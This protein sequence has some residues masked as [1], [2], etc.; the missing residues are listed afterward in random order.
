[1][2]NNVTSLIQDTNPVQLVANI[3]KHIEPDVPNV[4]NVAD[5]VQSALDVTDNELLQKIV[6]KQQQ[7][8]MDKNKEIANL[9]LNN[10]AVIDDYNEL[11]ARYRAAVMHNQEIVTSHYML[12]DEFVRLFDSV[13]AAKRQGSIPSII[14]EAI[15]VPPVN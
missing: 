1:M 7:Q 3:R 14:E 4:A 13:I 10:S 12:Q 2:A 8:L 11:L 9:K 5:E 15:K 6:N